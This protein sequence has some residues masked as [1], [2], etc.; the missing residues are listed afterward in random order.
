MP[1]PSPEPRAP[2][3][4]KYGI[5]GNGIISSSIWARLFI[6]RPSR[7]LVPEGQARIFSSLSRQL[8][9]GFSSPCM[10]VTGLVTVAYTVAIFRSKSHNLGYNFSV[11]VGKDCQYQKAHHWIY[12]QDKFEGTTLTSFLQD[13]VFFLESPYTITFL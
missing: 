5:C 7:S 6:S 8:V 4:L 10:H 2:A 12:S 1:A 11:D 3:A 13:S 9:L